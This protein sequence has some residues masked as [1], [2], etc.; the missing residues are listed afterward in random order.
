[1]LKSPKSGEGHTFRFTG[2]SE[3]MVQSRNPDEIVQYTYKK[4]P[5]QRA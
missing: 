5:G 2:P 4:W 3:M 1:M